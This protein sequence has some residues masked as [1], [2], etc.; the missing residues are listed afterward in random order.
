MAVDQ[1]TY[2]K[3]E[4][5]LLDLVVDSINHRF[6]AYKKFDAIHQKIDQKV[7]VFKAYLK[8]IKKKLSFFDEY[9]RAMLF[10]IKLTLVLKNKLLIMRNVSNIRK[11][12]LFKIIMQEITLSRTREDDGNS[13]NQHKNNKSFDNQFNRNQQSDKVRHFNKFEKNDKSDN[14][15]NTSAINKRTHAKMKNEKNNRCFECHKSRHYHR[16]CSKKNK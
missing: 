9:Y 12:I 16:N 6:I 13:N 8:E 2:L 15:F 10:L 1:I 5:F 11:T 14:H 7:S 4:Q 3:F